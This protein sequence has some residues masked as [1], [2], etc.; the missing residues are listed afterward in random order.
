[1]N[2]RPIS[3]AAL[4]AALLTLT[5][6]PAPAQTYTLPTSA[7]A[8]GFDASG[9]G[10][11]LR[12]SLGGAVAGH[13]GS[14][15]GGYSLGQGLWYPATGE[16]GFPLA[17]AVTP[18]DPL[19]PVVI[20]PG[21]R[22]HYDATF[23]VFTGGPE[24][25]EYW[26]TMTT[27]R[28]E[29][30]LVLGPVTLL[31]AVPTVQTL[32]QIVGGGRF[33]PPGVYT[34]TMY[35]G[36]YPSVVLASGGFNYT[37]DPHAHLARGSDAPSPDVAFDVADG[38]ARR[39]ATRA[40]EAAVRETVRE[41][42]AG[43]GGTRGAVA[44]RTAPEGEPGEDEWYVCDAEGNRVVAGTVL[45]LRF[46]PVALKEGSTPVA[47]VDAGSVSE[48]ASTSGATVEGLPSE[49][50]LLPAYPN[51]SAGR[52]TLPF[53]LPEAQPV[54][55]A[56]Y[57]VLGR[58]VAVLVDGEVEAGRHEAV[59]GAAALPS[60]VYVV[61]MTAGERTLTQRLTLVR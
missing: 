50:T 9:S 38:R 29:T 36:T 59:L 51:P 2:A 48:A 56:V 60:G 7:P 4:A 33:S 42:A 40:E 44:V 52:V 15:S 43:A 1:M 3:L 55:L 32:H 13:A 14:T 6:A 45:D 24:Q 5:A 30:R 8:S 53:A 28:G 20:R 37:V 16:S 41:R 21:Q 34:F 46:V 27:P 10:F 58:E 12:G 19:P 49:M 11:R 31:V 39:S 17:L 23:Y 18:T 35:V 26:A 22:V 57:D 61:Q 25:F 54:R 47:D